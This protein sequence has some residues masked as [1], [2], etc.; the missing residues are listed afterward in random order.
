MGA[1]EKDDG[2]SVGSF[3]YLDRELIEWG[4]LEECGGG[5]NDDHR[6]ISRGEKGIRWRILLQQVADDAV[7]NNGIM[8]R[9]ITGPIKKGAGAPKKRRR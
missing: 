2:W 9:R 3:I 1:T 6:W 5:R 7:K 4:L 8:K